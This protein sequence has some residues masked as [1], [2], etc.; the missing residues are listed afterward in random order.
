MKEDKV[1][2]KIHQTQAQLRKKHKC[3]SWNKEA[4]LIAKVARRVARRHGYRI[5]PMAKTPYT[6]SPIKRDFPQDP[7][8]QELHQIRRELTRNHSLK[9]TLKSIEQTTKSVSKTV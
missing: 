5:F 9:K 1:L 3:L 8:M 6:L 7:M 2:Q 4:K